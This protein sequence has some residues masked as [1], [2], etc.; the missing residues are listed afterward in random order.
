MAALQYP[1]PLPYIGLASE[2][3]L[4]QLMASNQLPRGL[5]LCAGAVAAVPEAL[6]DQ[7]LAEGRVSMCLCPAV[8]CVCT[9]V[10]VCGRGAVWWLRPSLGCQGPLPCLLREPPPPHPKMAP[11]RG[12]ST[13]AWQL[14]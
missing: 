3:F 4:H 8:L 14:L 10:S 13:P 12:F 9:R 6:Q 1:V 2:L 11:G 5:V 7:T